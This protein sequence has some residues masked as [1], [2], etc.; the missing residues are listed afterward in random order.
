VHF[1]QPHRRAQ[2]SSA[3]LRRHIDQRSPESLELSK[4]VLYING[5]LKFTVSASWRVDLSEH[6]Y[7]SAGFR[8]PLLAHHGQPVRSPPSPAHPPASQFLVWH[9]KRVFQGP[10]RYREPTPE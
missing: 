10:A 7:G 9:H 4:R 6:F 5:E 3:N 1:G 8:E 2:R